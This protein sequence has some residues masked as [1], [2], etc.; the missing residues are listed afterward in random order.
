[1]KE[2]GSREALQGKFLPWQGPARASSHRERGDH[3]PGGRDASGRRCE[4]GLI[5]HIATAPAPRVKKW[6]RKGRGGGPRIGFSVPAASVQRIE[7]RSQMQSSGAK[8]RK[9][10]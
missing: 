10:S 5:D 2:S 1:R 4:S 9:L 3:R 6:R 7:P 8:G